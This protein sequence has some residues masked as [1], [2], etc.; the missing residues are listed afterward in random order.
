MAGQTLYLYA[1][2][3]LENLYQADFSLLLS[4]GFCLCYSRSTLAP[5]AIMDHTIYLYLSSTTI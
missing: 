4:L 5:Q 3:R 1:S 2:L